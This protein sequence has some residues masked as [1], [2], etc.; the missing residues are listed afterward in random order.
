[1]VDQF[2][3]FTQKISIVLSSTIPLNRR[4]IYFEKRRTETGIEVLSLKASHPNALTC[5]KWITVNFNF[6]MKDF[7]NGI[8]K[9]LLNSGLLC[10]MSG[11]KSNLIF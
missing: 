6:Y 8:T 1:M 7:I 3:H 10:S 9:H 4:Y 2:H 11:T 5:L